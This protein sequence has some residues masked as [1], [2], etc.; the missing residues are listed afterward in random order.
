MQRSTS[1][2]RGTYVAALP[3]LFSNQTNT[4]SLNGARG[5]FVLFE[6]PNVGCNSFTSQPTH[7]TIMRSTTD[8]ICVMSRLEAINGCHLIEPD[9][10]RCKTNISTQLKIQNDRVASSIKSTQTN[11]ENFSN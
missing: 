7:V 1:Q 3:V 4:V 2:I 8:A 11:Y 5:E 6:K 9:C 10:V